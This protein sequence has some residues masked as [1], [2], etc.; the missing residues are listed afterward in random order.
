MIKKRENLTKPKVSN[1]EKEQNKQMVLAK[2]TGVLRLSCF[3]LNDWPSQV[4]IFILKRLTK[5]DFYLL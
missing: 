1:N 2:K 3:S 5:I 4:R